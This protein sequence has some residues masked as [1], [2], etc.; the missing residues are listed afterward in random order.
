MII[1]MIIIIVII[2]I[3]IITIIIIINIIDRW[4]DLISRRG[5]ILL[6]RKRWMT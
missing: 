3:I 6:S 5:L 1:M 2:I 4:T